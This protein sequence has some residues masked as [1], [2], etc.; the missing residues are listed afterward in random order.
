MVVWVVTVLQGVLVTMLESLIRYVVPVVS[1]ALSSLAD[2]K[3]IT[4]VLFVLTF[5]NRDILYYA[6]PASHLGGPN[7]IPGQAL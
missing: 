5:G 4:A 2:F 7:S 1:T 3:E 6:S